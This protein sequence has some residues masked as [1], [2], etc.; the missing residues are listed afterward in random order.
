MDL[1]LMYMVPIALFRPVQLQQRIIAHPHFEKRLEKKW[2]KERKE[3]SF[4]VMTVVCA[5]YMVVMC[6]HW[7]LCEVVV[8][9]CL[10]F[11]VGI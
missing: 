6:G 3:E 1:V 10:W 11:I 4:G 8:Q 7:I 2:K 5:S 9:V